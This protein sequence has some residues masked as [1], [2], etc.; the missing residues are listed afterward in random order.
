MYAVLEEL[1]SYHILQV[2]RLP[3]GGERSSAATGQQVG[4][5]S[6]ETKAFTQ[7]QSN[8]ETCLPPSG[9]QELWQVV[10]DEQI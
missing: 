2:Q 9:C 4:K 3:D 8:T 7:Q 10:I 5:E 6:W 1:L